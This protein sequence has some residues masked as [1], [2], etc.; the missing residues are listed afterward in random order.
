MD[1]ITT[2]ASQPLSRV[3]YLHDQIDA[4]TTHELIV[5]I[6][7]INEEDIHKSKMSLISNSVY[8]PDPIILDIN[9]PGGYCR[10]GFAL[11]SAIEASTTPVITRVSGYAYSMGFVI[12]L[13]GVERHMSKYA[14]LMYHQLSSCT[15]GT[16]KEM[17][18]NIEWSQLVQKRIEKYVISRT[19]LT[20]KDLKKVYKS[21]KDRVYEAEEALAL[22]IA[23]SIY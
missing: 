12:F 13:A 10:D 5:T 6:Q 23:T 15:W 17:E 20:E 19:N 8:K 3:L 2:S 18:E 14:D 21:K 11:L 9:S 16:L 4:D 22:G 7:N 1:L